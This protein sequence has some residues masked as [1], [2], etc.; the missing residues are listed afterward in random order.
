MFNAPDSSPDQGTD[1]I[2]TQRAAQLGVWGPGAHGDLARE[3]EGRKRL[4]EGAG[5]FYSNSSRD[6]VTI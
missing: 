3:S 2:E 5:L 1:A 4:R 6:V